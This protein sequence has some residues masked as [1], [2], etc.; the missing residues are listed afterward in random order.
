MWAAIV[1]ICQIV[2]LVLQAKFEKDTQERKRR[3]DLNAGW[4]DAIKSGD[5]ST[6]NNFVDKLRS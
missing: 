6:I 2:Y 3:D 5:T 1:G 4:K